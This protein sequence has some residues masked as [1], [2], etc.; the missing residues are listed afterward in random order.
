V[1]YEW[2]HR[3]SSHIHGFF[4]MEDAPSVDALNRDDAE[5]VEVFLH[6]GTI[7]PTWHPDKDC[8]P[9]A[10]TSFSSIVQ[11]IAGYKKQEL[12][13]CES[14]STP[15]QMCPGYCEHR[16]KDTGATFCRFGYP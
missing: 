9:A 16:K 7:C 6:F 14:P 2:Q 13:K 4:W 5:S 10:I 15:Y 11:Y 3:G 12:Q 1:E 8:S